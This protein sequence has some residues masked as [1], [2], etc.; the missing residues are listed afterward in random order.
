WRV[1]NNR[2]PSRGWLMQAGCSMPIVANPILDS[3]EHTPRPQLDPIRNALLARARF[4]RPDDQRLIELAVGWQLSCRQIARIL[5]RSG[6]AVS[7]RLRRL[8][9]L[10]H[11]PLVRDLLDPRC[12]LLEKT[13]QIAT[14]HFLQFKQPGTLAAEHRASRTQILGII[15]FVRGWHRGRSSRDH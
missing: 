1:P 14:E 2:L 13:R 4:L 8:I 3:I 12:P 11:D 5:G 10:L 9:R 6:G 7:R 15:E